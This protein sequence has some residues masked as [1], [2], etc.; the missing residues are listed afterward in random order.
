VSA[1]AAPTRAERCDA[2]DQEGNDCRPDDVELF[3][4]RERPVVLERRRGLVS[5]EIVGRL[6][7]VEVREEERGPD[8][9]AN[10]I[11]RP[12]EVEQEGGSDVGHRE[13]ECGRRQDPPRTPGVEPHERDASVP[14]RFR[15]Q[16]PRDQEAREDEEHVDADVAAAE[17]RDARVRKH[18][19]QN[20]DS[21]QTLNVVSVRHDS[22]LRA[23]GIPLT[24]I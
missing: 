8:T 12:D 1:D 13:G 22:P 23:W 7:E 17:E 5:G 19:E 10:R 16:D 18:D 6:P 21:S 2:H 9:V 3:L 4:D 15:E 11:A 14:L 20:G 24:P